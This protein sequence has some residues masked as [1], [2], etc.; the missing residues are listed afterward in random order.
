[1]TT[2]MGFSLDLPQLSKDVYKPKAL[3]LGLMTVLSELGFS[4]D[5]H[6][7]FKPLRCSNYFE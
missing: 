7:I 4:P 2:E 5:K 1:M 6:L 3:R